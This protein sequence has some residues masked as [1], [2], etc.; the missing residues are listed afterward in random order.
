MLSAE[1]VLFVDLGLLFMYNRMK[2]VKTLAAILG[3]GQLKA[4]IAIALSLV[5]SISF[6]GRAR[7]LKDLGEILDRVLDKPIQ[8]F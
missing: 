8:T 7:S 3:S 6:L 2:D 4:R 5:I 1:L